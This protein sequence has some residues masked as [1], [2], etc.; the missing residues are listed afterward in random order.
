MCATTSWT[1]H[2]TTGGMSAEIMLPVRSSYNATDLPVY[3]LVCTNCGFVRFHSKVA[4]DG[5]SS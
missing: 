2:A 3:A 4:V 5:I 1:L